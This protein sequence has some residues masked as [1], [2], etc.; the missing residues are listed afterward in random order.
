VHA[1]PAK[2]FDDRP[3]LL[4]NSLGNISRHALP[5]DAFTAWQPIGRQ[6]VKPSAATPTDGEGHVSR[7]S[8]SG[9]L[10]SLQ[11]AC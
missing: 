9:T 1:R 5:N 8:G 2:T 4:G 6:H 7:P 3:A 10:A 11:V